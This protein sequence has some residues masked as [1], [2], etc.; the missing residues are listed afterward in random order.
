[1]QKKTSLGIIVPCY[2]EAA[3]ISYF[4]T[5]LESFLQHLSDHRQDINVRFYIIENNSTDG[6][7]TQLQAL[8]EKFPQHLLIEQCKR[9]GYGASLKHGFS[10]FNADSDYLAFLDFD[11]TYPLMSLP[12]LLDKVQSEN[13]DMVFGARLHR[14][15]QIDWVRHLGNAFYVKLL[16]TLI[17]AEL[18]DVCSGM[19]VFKSSLA[20]SIA[21]L[22]EDDLSFSIQLTSFAHVKKWKL[23]EH[24][25]MYR[26]RVGESKLSVVSDGV[27][28]LIVLIKTV[29]TNKNV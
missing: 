21:S 27:K 6:T 17:R 5:E 20:G 9:Q 8:S 26:A 1:M 14:D 28:F 19:R 29:L 7:Y 24:S 16:R 10:K 4:Q 12:P 22:S 2:N 23:G 25:I 18:S 13:L 15:S 11:N 3:N